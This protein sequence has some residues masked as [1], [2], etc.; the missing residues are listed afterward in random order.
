ML[1]GTLSALHSTQEGWEGG[2]AARDLYPG[3][4]E[5]PVSQLGH[6]HLVDRGQARPWAGSE[7]RLLTLT[8]SWLEGLGQVTSPDS[9]C[10]LISE[11]G[12][13]VS[14][15]LWPCLHVLVVRVSNPTFL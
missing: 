6:G 3:K 12:G 13:P 1:Q 9:L 8:S 15:V 14:C 4:Q 5:R 7:V 11:M 2:T 10:F